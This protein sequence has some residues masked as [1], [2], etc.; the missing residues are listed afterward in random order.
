VQSA[1]Q[2]RLGEQAVRLRQETS[3]P[4]DGAVTIRV[5]VNVPATFGLRL[6][7]PHWCSAPRLTVNGAAIDLAGTLEGGYTHIRRTWQDGDAVALE[8]PMPAE[9]IYAHPDVRADV[10]CAALRRGPL[11]YCLEQA[12]HAVPLH[13]VLLPAQ[14]ELT[15]R[16]D[17][18]LLGGVVVL[19]GRGAALADAGW[20][21]V[22]YR[23]TP[24]ETEPCDIRAI[25]YYAWDNRT[26]GPMTVWLHEQPCT[27]TPAL[28]RL[29]IITA[30]AAEK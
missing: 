30:K 29:P 26:P 22:L 17:P 13:R 7:L 28:E 4:W 18:E 19:E 6:R 16:F 10:G 8:L 3:Y 23:T 2:L 21:D 20:D 1:V 27:A 5:G 12:D 9:R 24:P 11:V 15:A 25:P 14:A